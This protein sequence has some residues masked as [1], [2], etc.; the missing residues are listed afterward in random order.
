MGSIAI[1]GM[2]AA[3]RSRLHQLLRPVSGRL[4]GSLQIKINTPIFHKRQDSLWFGG[5]VVKIHYRGWCFSLWAN[6]DVYAD[7]YE[8][9]DMWHHFYVK[10]KRNAGNLA[11]ELIRYIKSDRA[12]YAAM[13]GKHPRYRL[14]TD[15]NNWWEAFAISP[16]GEF[17]DLMWCLDSDKIL[18]AIAEI[19]GGMD[20]IIEAEC[21]NDKPGQELPQK[22]IGGERLC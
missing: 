2:S 3:N 14:E 6:G 12:L 17:I 5:E 22:G 16:K 8:L 18:P 9:P 1:N 15:H 13:Q 4:E 7:L 11:G 19:V 20:E 21:G 10:D